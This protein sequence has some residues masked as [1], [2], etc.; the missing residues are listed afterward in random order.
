MSKTSFAPNNFGIIPEKIIKSGRVW[1][2]I[3]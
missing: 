1:Y 3:T 2:W